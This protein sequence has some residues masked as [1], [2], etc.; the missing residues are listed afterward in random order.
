MDRFSPL[1]SP[2][3]TTLH[4]A[5]NKDEG[6]FGFT[7][8]EAGNYMACFWMHSHADNVPASIELD[9]KFGVAA[10][11]WASIAKKEKLES[12][13]ISQ[14]RAV[15]PCREAEMRGVNETTNARV[16]WFSIMSLF[17]CLMVAAWQL[18]HL[19]SYFER[20]KIL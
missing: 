10:K 12:W 16:A 14:R 15:N 2:Y 7:T 1:T 3:G 13:V 20:K 8:T 17:L 9:W 6:Q 19:K 4:F 5:E 11:D 18:W